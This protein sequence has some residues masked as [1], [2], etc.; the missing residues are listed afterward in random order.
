MADIKIG[1]L[2]NLSPIIGCKDIVIDR[3]TALGNP[4]DMNKKQTREVVVA[5]YRKYLWRCIQMAEEDPCQFPEFDE[6]LAIAP[7]YRYPEVGV[8]VAKLEAITRSKDD[9]RLLCWCSPAACHG[10]I[11]RSCVLWMRK[12]LLVHQ[13]RYRI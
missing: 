10:D 2:K 3:T 13:D 1:S 5:A 12:E 9:I 7:T 4:Y 8:V 11:I 6:S